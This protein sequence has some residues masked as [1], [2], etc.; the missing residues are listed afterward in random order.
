MGSQVGRHRPRVTGAIAL[1]VIATLTVAACG[2]AVDADTGTDARGTAEDAQDADDASAGDGGDEAEDEAGEAPVVDTEVAEPVLQLVATLPPIADLVQQVGGDRV[3]VTSLVPSGA[4]AH[5][6]EP[7]PQ[8]VVGLSGADAYLG[9]GLSLNDGA[10]R[11]AEETLPEGAPVVLLGESALTPDALVLDHG[12]SHGDDDHG[13]SHGDDDHGHSHGDD[14]EELGPNPH[15]WTS[16]RNAMGL[17]EGIRDALIDLDPDGEEHYAA[18]ADAYLAELS[19]LD[20]RV[21]DAALTIPA[22]N[23][24]L[25][26]YHDAWTYFARDHDLTFATAI[27]PADYAEPSASEV[28][29]LI[30]LIRDLDVPVVFGSEEFPTPVLQAIA[31]ETE[32]TYVADL[33]DDVLPGE[34]G[35][36]EHTYLE[37]MRRNAVTIIGNLGGDTSQL[38]G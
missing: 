18:N 2:P 10:L 32:A 1:L 24:T 13:H 27:Q 12:H 33:S 3:S 28:R 11:L 16:L 17:V 35:A 36:A 34:P 30:D 25:V 8:D 4:D 15:V 21:R 19:D 23:R 37:L 7:R 29:G 38:T 31:E 6:Y 26:T 5:T 20:R 22:A 9:V 14:G